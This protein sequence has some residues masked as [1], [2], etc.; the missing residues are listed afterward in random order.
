VERKA[1]QEGHRCAEQYRKNGSFPLLRDMHAF[2]VSDA[3]EAF[4]RETPWGALY[5]MT[6]GE[7]P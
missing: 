5:F 4:C 1:L 7:A 3:Y 6:S 2:Q